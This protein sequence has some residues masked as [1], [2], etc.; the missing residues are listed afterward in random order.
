MKSRDPIL[1]RFCWY[2]DSS[3]VDTVPSGDWRHGASPALLAS[4]SEWQNPP[5]SFPARESFF[6]PRQ[7]PQPVKIKLYVLGTTWVIWINQKCEGKRGKKEKT[8]TWHLNTCL[9]LQP[10]S[11]LRE[12]KRKLSGRL[13]HCK[14]KLL[15]KWDCHIINQYYLCL[16]KRIYTQLG[17][18][19]FK[20]MQFLLL[21]LST[22]F[23][24]VI[25]AGSVLSTQIATR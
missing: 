10:I 24:G 19:K 18:C 12:S 14:I 22:P 9:S 1:P 2:L 5:C 17:T 23:T 20:Q 16:R 25:S 11:H 13:A 6:H 3:L 15:T 4:T 7:I 21:N 8:S